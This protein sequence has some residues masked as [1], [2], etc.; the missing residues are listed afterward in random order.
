MK[1]KG[2]LYLIIPAGS[3][4]LA[5]WILSSGG[6]PGGKSGS[7]G[8]GGTSCTQCHA[9]TAQQASE[10]ITSNIPATGYV[11]GQTYTITAT[12]THNGVQKFGFE[13][14]A[15]DFGSTKKGTFII[16]NAAQTKL[17]NGAKAVTH[18]SGGTTPFGNSK[19]WTFDWT[20]PVAGTGQVTFYG[21]FNAANGNGSNSGDV[22]YL[23]SAAFNEFTTSITDADLAAE[24]LRIFP[25]P[26]TDFIRMSANHTGEIR[27]VRIAA[28]TGAVVFSQNGTVAGEIII[29]TS[30]Y[31]KG[32]YFLQIFFR[33]GSLISRKVFRS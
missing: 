16:T 13:V 12:G 27:E 20:A 17:V 32:T 1:T 8:D 33:D 21:A 3:M 10:W 22:I 26:F 29:N 4:I 24:G 2:L 31:P 6:S 7:P 9:G 5:S 25:N 30:D 19:T 14:T 18:T 11:P 15:E 28:S 23:S